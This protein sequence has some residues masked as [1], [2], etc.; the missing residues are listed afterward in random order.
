MLKNITCDTIK[1]YN[2]T[3]ENEILKF[4][5]IDEICQYFRISRGSAHKIIKNKKTTIEI[6][7]KSDG[8]IKIKS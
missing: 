1:E 3:L 6:K 7:K 8:K 2:I 5:T 4:K